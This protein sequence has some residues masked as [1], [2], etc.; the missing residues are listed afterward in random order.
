MPVHRGAFRSCFNLAIEILVIS[1]R[2]RP[3]KY[4]TGRVMFQ[5]RNRDSCHFRSILRCHRGVPAA[6]FNLAI[7][8]LVISGPCGQ[9]P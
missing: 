6:S 3:F 9:P 7:E 2:M 5:S 1:G 4:P 8:I